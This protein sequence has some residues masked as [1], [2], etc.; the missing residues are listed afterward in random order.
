LFTYINT[1]THHRL[2]LF[3]RNSNGLETASSSLPQN[4]PHDGLATSKSAEV[5]PPSTHVLSQASQREAV[6]PS[7]IRCATKVVLR[8]SQPSQHY[9][10]ED[11]S[12][13]RT[14]VSESP[15]AEFCFQHATCNNSYG[16]FSERKDPPPLEQKAQKHSS[17]Q[18]KLKAARKRHHPQFNMLYIDIINSTL[19]KL[20]YPTQTALKL[21]YNTHPP[22]AREKRP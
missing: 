22:L 5:H 16:K 12:H 20:A 4:S 15:K 1:K 6:T 9:L 2:G 3:P 7:S 13:P 14:H 8:D 17:P 10:Q 19:F 11:I 21:W 18:L